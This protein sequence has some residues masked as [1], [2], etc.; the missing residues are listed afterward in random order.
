MKH[1]LGFEFLVLILKQILDKPGEKVKSI[2]VD[3]TRL[4]K[5]RDSKAYYYRTVTCTIELI[6]KSSL[7]IEGLY[8]PSLYT[9]ALDIDFIL[10]EAY[11]PKNK[12]NTLIHRIINDK[13]LFRRVQEIRVDQ[14]ILQDEKKSKNW[15]L[16][17]IKLGVH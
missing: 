16:E 12:L 13:T 15:N 6:E 5:T 3:I 8:D 14:S 1:T 17:H 7:V 4:R 10:I 9:Q 2:Q 11:L